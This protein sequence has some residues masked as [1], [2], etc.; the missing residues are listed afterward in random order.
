[1]KIHFNFLKIIL[2]VLL[3]IILNNKL[4]QMVCIIKCLIFKLPFNSI[5]IKMND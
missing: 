5:N 1:M 3:Q 4:Y 2:N